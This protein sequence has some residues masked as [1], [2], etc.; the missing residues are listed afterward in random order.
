MQKNLTLA[1]EKAR[2]IKLLILDVDGVMTDGR[3][4]FS[5]QGEIFKAFNILDGLG[6]KLLRSSGVEVAIITGRKSGALDKR[7]SDLG[8]KYLWQGRE[9]KRVALDEL[10]AE[11]S[12]GYSEVAHVGDDLPDLPVMQTVG[13]GIA[14]A[15]AYSF[16]TRHADWCTTAKGGE[17][18]VREAC[19]FIMSAQGTLE[20]QLNRYL[21]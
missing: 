15:N 1:Q 17:G 11:L 13:L 12:L 16:V 8:I 3:L 6:I 7:T 4:Y 9:D 2:H 21:T 5:E 19:D 18:A 20:I 10:L 14:V